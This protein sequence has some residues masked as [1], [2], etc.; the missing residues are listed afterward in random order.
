MGTHAWERGRWCRWNLCPPLAPVSERTRGWRDQC[1][2]QQQAIQSG[3]GGRTCSLATAPA[4]K[5][6]VLGTLAAA[7]RPMSLYWE[8]GRP[9]T[10]DVGGAAVAGLMSSNERLLSHDAMSAAAGSQGEVRLGWPWLSTSN[11]KARRQPKPGEMWWNGAMDGGAYQS[12]VGMLSGEA[13]H[14]K[15]WSQEVCC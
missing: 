14:S 11:I 4:R 13:M 10:H 2:W 15:Q 12:V 3:S 1:G 6:E 7:P 8:S 9:L 5:L